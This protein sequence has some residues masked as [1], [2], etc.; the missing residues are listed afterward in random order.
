MAPGRTGHARGVLLAVEVVENPPGGFTWDG[1]LRGLLL[2]LA[3]VAV[4]RALKPLVRRLLLLRRSPSFA[5]VFASLFALTCYVVGLLVAVT[6]AFPSVRPVDVLSSLGIVSV[7]V[8]FAFRDV[9]QNLL[10]GVLLL[11]RDPFRGGDQI[12]V[13]GV[14]GTVEEIDLRF[15]ILRGFDGTQQLV[16]NT[17][18]LTEVVEVR[19][20][21]EAVR[22][23]VVVGVDYAS[24]LRRAR[25]AA[26]SAL[27]GADGVLESPVPTV[28]VDQLNTSTVDL[29]VRWWTGPQQDHVLAVRDR[30]VGAVKEALDE[31]GVEMPADVVVLQG[32]PSLRATLHRDAEVTPGGGVR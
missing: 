8:G 11:L 30:A 15:T 21:Y 2:L 31:A 12:T 20:G 6:A 14:T 1:G 22:S 32:S 13:K 18:V 26:L 3:F 17:A 9:L 27:D 4:G 19:T 5:R 23:E 24:D 28:R 10:A 25:E 29:L 7:A 16:P